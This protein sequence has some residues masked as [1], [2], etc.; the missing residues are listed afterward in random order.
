MLPLQKII[1]KSIINV[2]IIDKCEFS[3]INKPDFGSDNAVSDSF[4]SED[5]DNNFLNNNHE[6]PKKYY[7]QNILNDKLNPDLY[8][9]NSIEEKIEKNMDLIFIKISDVNRNTIFFNY[10]SM[11]NQLS[12]KNKKAFDSENF[13][14]FVKSEDFGNSQTLHFEYFNS[15]TLKIILTRYKEKNLNPIT[16]GF[17]ENKFTIKN[18]RKNDFFPDVYNLNEKEHTLDAKKNCLVPEF[19]KEKYEEKIFL[20]FENDDINIEEEKNAVF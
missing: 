13:L 3:K 12:V 8:S 11:N 17:G 2:K 19:E 9:T 4:E 10:L 16:V 1:Q 5:S 6:N 18:C 15:D 14:L 7:D 20:F